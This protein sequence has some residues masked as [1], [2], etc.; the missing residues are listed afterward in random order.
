MDLPHCAPHGEDARHSTCTAPG[1]ASYAQPG[2]HMNSLIYIVGL[3][4]VI[5]AILSFFGLR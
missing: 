5:I 4:V 3:I 2:T 1:I